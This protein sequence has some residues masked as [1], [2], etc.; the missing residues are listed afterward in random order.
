MSDK[1]EYGAVSVID[2]STSLDPNVSWVQ[3]HIM[4]EEQEQETSSQPKYNDVPFSILF[5]IHLAIFAFTA[6][7]YGSWDNLVS[8]EVVNGWMEVEE[9]SIEIRN[10]MVYLVLPCGIA[11][12]TIPSFF[13][14]VLIP[15]FPKGAVIVSLLSSMFVNVIIAFALFA[16]YPTWWMFLL[17]FGLVAWSLWYVR[18]IQIF[19]PYA[20]ATL[21]L[22][23]R[24]VTAN[25]GMYIVSL[26]LSAL[27]VVWV[28][29]WVYVANG[30]GLW[31][32]LN[33][34]STTSGVGVQDQDQD[35]DQ[36]QAN[37]SVQDGEHQEYPD[38]TSISIMAFVLLL[39]L[40][41]TSTVL[42]VSRNL[43]NTCSMNDAIPY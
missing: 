18:A 10:I 29:A 27:G 41:W 40:Y 22:G 15:R 14:G 3:A 43:Y 38:T 23:V 5:Y 34:A 11:A 13:M 17:S 6:V 26:V 32:V 31:D 1:L 30:V 4:K 9:S 7:F 20:A 28:G 12:F 37:T 42:M 8:D 35:Q 16:S 2:A 21:K 24:G 39:S 19:I 25:W 33:Q 36:D